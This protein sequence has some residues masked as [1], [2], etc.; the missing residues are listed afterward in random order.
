M[1]KPVQ[2]SIVQKIQLK[3][4]PCFNCKNTKLTVVKDCLTT[5]KNK[6]FYYVECT[7]CAIVGEAGDTPQQAI[8][9]WIKENEGE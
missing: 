5:D 7:K 1:K 9:F 8:D 3:N 6:F 2:L 4:S